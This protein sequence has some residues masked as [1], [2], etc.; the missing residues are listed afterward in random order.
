MEAVRW[1]QEVEL[2]QHT[3]T[4]VAQRRA[5]LVRLRTVHRLACTAVPVLASPPHM[6]NLDAPS[7]PLGR[8]NSCVFCLVEYQQPGSGAF[9]HT[10]PPSHAKKWPLQVLVG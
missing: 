2:A 3:P 10:A 9:P 5:D 8:Q 4:R 6:D 7:L 1:R